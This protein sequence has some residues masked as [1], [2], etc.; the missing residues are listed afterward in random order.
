MNYKD[1]LTPTE[2]AY[3]DN[4]REARTVLRA[5]EH[6]A[7]LWESLDA[8]MGGGNEATISYVKEFQ[9]R[10]S[11]GELE[12]P[13]NPADVKRVDLME[14]SFLYKQLYPP[15]VAGILSFQTIFRGNRTRKG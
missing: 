2:K 6:Y 3:L 9:A 1:E 13:D 15:D 8:R 5:L 10:E 12:Q 4:A 7:G 14:A 11:S